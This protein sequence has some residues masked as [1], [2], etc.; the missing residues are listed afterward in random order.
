M[1]T[2]FRFSR[3]A[4]DADE[5]PT[6]MH[7]DVLP[8]PRLEERVTLYLRAV[9]GGREFTE[10]ER[11]NARNLLLDSMAAEIAAQVITAEQSRELPGRETTN[12]WN[13]GGV[14]VQYSRPEKSPQRQKRAIEPEVTEPRPPSKVSALYGQMRKEAITVSPIARSRTILALTAT[15]GIVLMVTGGSLGY[16]WMH[17]HM[18]DEVIAPAQQARV[19]PPSTSTHMMD[20]VTTPA[21]QARVSPNATPLSAVPAP[22]LTMPPRPIVPP[23][24]LEAFRSDTQAPRQGKTDQ[25]ARKQ[26][27]VYIVSRGTLADVG[28]VFRRLQREQPTLF[29]QAT[30][31]SIPLSDRSTSA[32]NALQAANSRPQTESYI[33]LQVGPFAS[34]KDAEVACRGFEAAARNLA[35][36]PQ[37]GVKPAGVGSDGQVECWPSHRTFPTS[38]KEPPKPR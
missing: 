31:S 20:E 29:G 38:E 27:V 1:I 19:P 12:G 34:E 2:T 7:D 30:L 18:V 23:T 8:V 28:A 11:S 9:H 14:L 10:E 32:G 21:R 36:P 15:F 16:R 5:R 4:G 22:P 25:A 3:F 17:P 37:V 35:P 24:P 13:G 33:A 6:N 26:H